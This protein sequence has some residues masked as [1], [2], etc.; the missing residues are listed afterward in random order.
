MVVAPLV[1]SAATDTSKGMSASAAGT[2]A[3]GKP[4]VAEAMVGPEMVGDR[5]REGLEMPG[6]VEILPESCQSMDTTLPHGEGMESTSF[7][8]TRR[9]SDM[10]PGT[11]SSSGGG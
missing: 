1:E 9:L 7:V 11:D 10:G 8:H 3:M 2:E 4:E 5:E 6:K